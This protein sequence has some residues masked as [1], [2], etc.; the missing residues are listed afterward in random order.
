VEEV[1]TVPLPKSAHRPF[2][3]YVNGV[4]Q[5][6]GIDYEVVGR[7]LAFRKPLSKEGKLG[8]VRW[9]SIFLGIAG[10]YRKNDSVDVVYEVG[11]RRVVSTG[12][13]IIPPG[14]ARG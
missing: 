12:L 8:L 10:T 13:E 5:E 14:S 3:V 11:G 1:W 6:E 7:A 2:E 9:A 4:L